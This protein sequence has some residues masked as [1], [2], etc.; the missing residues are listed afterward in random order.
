MPDKTLHDLTILVPESRE[1]DLFAGM[2]EAQ[3]ARTWR[4]PLVAIKPLDEFS[5]VDTWL[6]RLSAGAL[7]DLVLTTGEGLRHLL[8]RAADTGAREPVVAALAKL[9]TVVRGPKPVRVL[10]ELGLSPTIVA[11]VPTTEGLIAAL[12]AHELGGRQVG[13][14]L[15]PGA[16]DDLASFVAQRG[17]VPSPVTPYRY[18]SD[19]DSDAVEAAIREMAAGRI[20][21]A[22]FTSGS[23]VRR[24]TEVARARQLERELEEGFARTKVAAVGPVVAASLEAA[25]ATIAAQPASSFHLKPL[26]AAMAAARK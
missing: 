4:C 16:G 6:S 15:Y 17:G 20:D 3:G 5:A 9:R 2:L 10:R 25:G 18:A 21:F 22:A 23:Q 19:A 8:A 1:L 14:Q 13:I 12:S 11:E 7:N 26:I 24:L